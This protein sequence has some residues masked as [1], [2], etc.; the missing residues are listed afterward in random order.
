MG[1]VETD[2]L[3]CDGNQPCRRCQGKFDPSRGLGTCLI[4]AEAQFEC[5]YARQHKKRGR[6]PKK[7]QSSNATATTKDSHSP[8]DDPN[9]AP[10]TDVRPHLDSHAFSGHSF[11][12]EQELLATPDIRTHSLLASQQGFGQDYQSIVLASTQRAFTEAGSGRRDPSTGE[13]ST[14]FP[15]QSPTSTSPSWNNHASPQLDMRPPATSIDSLRYPVLRPL[16]PML[17][18][19][20]SSSLACDLLEVYFT[21]S[22]SAQLRPSSPHVLGYVF[23][24]KSFLHPTSP[25]PSSPAL[26][27]SMLWIAAQTSNA[28]VLS[29]H[30]T[31]RGRICRKLLELTVDLLKPLI[32]SPVPGGSTI[33]GPTNHVIDDVSLGVLGVSTDNDSEEGSMYAQVDILVTYIHLATIVSA[34]ERKAASLRWWHSAWSLARELKLG[35]EVLPNASRQSIGEYRRDADI[36]GSFSD[37]RYMPQLAKVSMADSTHHSKFLSEE[38]REERRRAWWLLY[39]MDRHLALCYNRQLALL[40][41][42]CCN[43]LQPVDDTLWQSAH[44]ESTMLRN[45]PRRH[46][47]PSIICTGPGVFGYFLPAM[48]L[49]GQIVDLNLARNRPSYATGYHNPN[50]YDED[51]LDLGRQL[52]IYAQSVRDLE[53]QTL[54]PVA[55]ELNVDALYEPSAYNEAPTPSVKSSSTTDSHI[56]SENTL[57]LKTAIAYSKQIMHVLAIL[58]SGKWDP[59]TLLEDRDLWIST[60][61]FVAATDH[62]IAAAEAVGT[63]LEVDPDLSF[64]PFFFGIYL[65][66]GSF[67]LLLFADKLQG[68]VSENLVKACEYSIRA[69]EASVVTLDTLYQVR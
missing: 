36:R 8:P 32:H 57:L 56:Q 9:T 35:R 11:Q 31:A 68:D 52:E 43:L 5:K 1:L 17:E 46:A 61:S 34:S 41:R 38:Q 14:P 63:I 10:A 49:L 24:K 66:Q 60:D 4:H 37:G 3:Q 54:A 26:L 50:K 65:L 62:A 59:I 40:D 33:H 44:F 27:A 13:G 29:S 16:L 12:Y 45:P 19:I 18:A 39:S 30:P 69:H 25:R 6:A 7:E 53:T 51:V 15:N 28:T 58:V 2:Q 47:G 42:D 55:A 67:L 64:M 23:R 22:S 20:I 48:T 21:S